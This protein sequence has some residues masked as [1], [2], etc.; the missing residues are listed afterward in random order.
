MKK[1]LWLNVGG[2]AVTLMLVILQLETSTSGRD[3]LARS[4][5]LAQVTGRAEAI[6]TNMMQMSDAMR[7]Y[8]LDTTRQD[9]W[10]RKMKADEDLSA[11]V[12]SVKQLADDPTLLDLVNRIGKL[13]DERL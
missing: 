1:L 5:K 3:A 10:A 12:A 13:D 11:T 2:L 9:E 4:M 8:L 6:Q 7:G